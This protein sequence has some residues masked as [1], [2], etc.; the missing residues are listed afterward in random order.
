MIIIQKNAFDELSKAFFVKRKPR[1]SRVVE[2]RLTDEEKSS[3]C[4]IIKKTC[5]SKIKNTI[6]G[7]IY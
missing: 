3:D 1:D 4:D 7:Y 6:G 2:K 5:Q